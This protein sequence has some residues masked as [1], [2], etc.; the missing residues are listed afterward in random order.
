VF[1]ITSCK[2]GQTQKGAETAGKIKTEVY[3]GE[4]KILQKKPNSK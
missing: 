3:C 1:V 4:L 2:I